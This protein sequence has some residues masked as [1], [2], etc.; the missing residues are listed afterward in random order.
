MKASLRIAALALLALVLV[1][2]IP[3]A[4]NRQAA[5]DQHMVMVAHDAN[6]WVVE[7]P[8]EPV[9]PPVLSLPPAASESTAAVAPAN[10]APAP[11]PAKDDYENLSHRSTAR[12]TAAPPPPRPYESLELF[13]HLPPDAAKHQPL[14][15]LIVLHGMGSRGDAFSQNLIAEA[16]QNHWVIIAPTFPYGDYMQPPNLLTEDLR[17]S[18]MLADLLDNMPK[19]LGIKL[20]RDNL[21]YGFSRGA[22]LGHRFSLLYPDRLRA[23]VTISAGAYTLPAERRNNDAAAP[24]LQMPYGV[25]D[26]EKYVGH[27]LD[28]N[29]LRT[30]AFLIQV[31][32]NDN[33][34][35]E[36]PRQ[37]DALGKNRLARAYA[38]EYAL[39]NVGV[40]S[41]VSVF[42]GAGH[43]VTSEMRRAALEFLRKESATKTK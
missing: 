23:I 41:Q 5:R 29:Q 19:K 30:V 24:L 1:G 11:A 4:L 25:G 37:F 10:S 17:F 33:A 39:T 8:V 6:D 22:Q 26:L 40:K 28:Y 38:F 14:R 43:E 13:I 35:D 20:H 12:D 15:A 21:V 9:A 36:V 32:A 31:G 34:T 27:A 7:K 2:L 3:D 16:D 42:P 18:A